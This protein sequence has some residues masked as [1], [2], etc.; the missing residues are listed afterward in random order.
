[1][2]LQQWFCG[3]L[4]A[5][6][7]ST[8]AGSD[9][10]M[11]FR[12]AEG[13]EGQT[14]PPRTETLESWQ[15]KQASRLLSQATF[16][17]TQEEIDQVVRMGAD[18]WLDYQ[19]SL[20]LTLH[21]PRV[22]QRLENGE[23]DGDEDTGP[24]LQE[25]RMELWWDRALFAQDQLRQRVALAL[26]EILVVSDETDFTWFHAVGMAE[27]Y[28]IL[29][30]NA[31]G[32]YRDLLEDVSRS[33]MMGLYLSHLQNQ[34]AWPEENI[35]PDENYAREILQLFSIGLWHLNIDGSRRL[36]AS[37]KPIPTYNQ[38]VIENFARVF[39][40]WNYA[41]A[42]EWDYYFP[43]DQFLWRPME[44]YVNQHDW[45]R[46]GGY[47]DRDEKFLL[48]Y[49][50]EGMASSDW[51]RKRLPALVGDEDAATDLNRALDVI[52]NHPN[53]G[54][55]ISRQL[56]QHLVTSNPSPDYVARV[57]RVFNDNG[58][59]VRG[60]L[61]ATVK[62]ILTDVEAR[63]GHMTRPQTF[64]KLR[65]PLLRQTQMWRALHAMPIGGDWV[66][67]WYPEYFLAQAP[68]RS[69]SVF[70]FF[71]PGFAPPGEISERG[72]VAP[73][74]QITNETYVS[75][76]ANKIWYLLFQGYR[77]SPYASADAMELDLN[78]LI[79]LADR[80]QALLDYLDLLFMAGQMSD[81]M[82][83]VLMDVA[84]NTA[85]DNEWLDGNTTPGT[86]RVMSVLYVLLTS[87]EY[88]VQK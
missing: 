68:L 79:D 73:E 53:V 37:G 63:Y 2:K 70:N 81:G 7:I 65:E 40:G 23:G 46:E 60:D 41:D 64:G 34:R 83:D 67:D 4:L 49:P 27:Y 62:A 85:M 26:S 87:P 75:R 61:Y 72:L 51:P 8:A 76:T 86:F 43:D 1:M 44:P 42:P 25:L 33:P 28:D 5:G 31:L 36:D 74:F 16:G 35:R 71:T 80:P 78:P 20:P 15:R 30:R 24:L 54:P 50:V 82:R 52:F 88:V 69:P 45:E 10:I 14:L 11:V 21:R 39:T 84:Q 48:A 12:S 29:V 3:L 66:R 6:M 56:I 57:A 38:D 13:P 18:A 59:G 47:H 77:G 17:A 58:Q 9:M 22:Q 19:K 55:F 32:N